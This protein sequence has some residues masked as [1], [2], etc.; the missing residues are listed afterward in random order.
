MVATNACIKFRLNTRH[1]YPR[2]SSEAC[3]MHTGLETEEEDWMTGR[4]RV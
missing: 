4:G 1:L 3:E 2:G